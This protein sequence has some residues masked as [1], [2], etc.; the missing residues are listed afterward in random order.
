MDREGMPDMG[1]IHGLAQLEQD[2]WRRLTPRRAVWTDV[3]RFDGRVAELE[4]RKH[5]VT[6][7]LQDVHLRLANV[8]LADA[9]RV[10][11]WELGDHKGARP[12]PERPHLERERD[13]LE[14]ERDGLAVAISKVLEEKSAYVTKHRTRLV[15]E[16][17]KATAAAHERMAA[18][19]DELAEARTDLVELR[20]T[21]LWAA[22]YPDE[23]AGRDPDVNLIAGGL[24]GPHKQAGLTQALE[25]ARALQ[26][27]R[28]DCDWL[29][30]ASTAEQQAQLEGRDPRQAPGAYWTQTPEGQEQE[31]AEKQA[32]LRRYREMWGSDPA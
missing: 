31:R 25:A 23:M 18:A 11:Q 1:G 22:L 7:A 29:R 24:R 10:A 28:D 30:R 6:T 5:E 27:L 26:L 15:R 16:A 20:V 4:R 2:S 9:E 8:D 12:E 13:R 21:A 17:D 14:H 19:V 32:A 3:R